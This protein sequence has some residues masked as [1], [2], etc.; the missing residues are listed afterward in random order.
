MVKSFAKYTDMIKITV[1]GQAYFTK[2]EL[3]YT[4]VFCLS[5]QGIR[6]CMKVKANKQRDKKKKQ[7]NTQFALSASTLISRNAQEVNNC[8]V[9]SIPKILGY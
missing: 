1:V 6:I 2:L 7:C 5:S 3:T 9:C 4:L 8:D